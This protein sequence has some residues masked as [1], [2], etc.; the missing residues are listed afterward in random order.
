MH[1]I[2]ID[3]DPAMGV[4]GRDVD[5]ALAIALALNSPEIE[6]LGLTVTYGNTSLPR[7]VRSARR[8][9]RAAGREDIP[10]LPG[11]ASRL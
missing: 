11:A 7:A 10:V 3:T 4:F 9:L 2:I 1:K 8:L 5:D 6:V